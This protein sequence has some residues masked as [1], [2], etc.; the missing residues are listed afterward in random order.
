[1][2]NHLEANFLAVL[3]KVVANMNRRNKSG[4]INTNQDAKVN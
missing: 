2:K 3:L 1:M 4:F